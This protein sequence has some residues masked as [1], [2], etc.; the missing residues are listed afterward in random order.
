MNCSLTNS[1]VVDLITCLLLA[2]YLH[3][4]KSDFQR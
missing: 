2:Y 4:Y 1:A 3:K